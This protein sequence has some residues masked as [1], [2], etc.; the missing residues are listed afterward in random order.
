MSLASSP[1]TVHS[2][3]HCATWD[4]GVSTLPDSY[5]GLVRYSLR[6]HRLGGD[7]RL[8][9]F[10]SRQAP[11]GLGA[12]EQSESGSDNRTKQKNRWHTEHTHTESTRE[13]R[14]QQERI[15]HPTI[16][17][18]QRETIRS[19]LARGPLA[20]TTTRQ[21]DATTIHWRNQRRRTPIRRPT[22]TN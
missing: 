13:S 1:L 22:R 18:I 12:N 3:S 14:E 11:V 21:T 5:Y 6:A 16:R 8:Y 20:R 19:S 2:S 9:F 17:T 4:V 7:I 10:Q 15:R